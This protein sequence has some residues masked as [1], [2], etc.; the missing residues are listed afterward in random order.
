MAFIIDVLTELGMSVSDAK[1]VIIDGLRG[2]RKPRLLKPLLVTS[3]QG[4]LLEACLSSRLHWH[5][6]SQ[7]APVSRHCLE[8]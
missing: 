4:L 8:L 7:T 5:P 3:D 1:T 6:A 2:P